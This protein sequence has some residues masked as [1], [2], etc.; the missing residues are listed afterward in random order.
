MTVIMNRIKANTQIQLEA[1][2][3]KLPPIPIPN[4]KKN[5]TCKSKCFPQDSLSQ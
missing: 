1:T 3:S 4:G 5:H 2:E